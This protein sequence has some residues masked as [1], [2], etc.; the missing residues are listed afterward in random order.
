MLLCKIT[1]PEIIKIQK[2]EQRQGLCWN[3]V[4]PDWQYYQEILL[5]HLPLPPHPRFAN[6]V[7]K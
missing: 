6:V 4:G 3:Y 1:V 5:E 2:K 7:K